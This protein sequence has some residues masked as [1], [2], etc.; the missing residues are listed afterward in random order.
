MATPIYPIEGIALDSTGDMVADSLADR[1]VNLGGAEEHV[2]K[3]TGTVHYVDATAGSD[4]NDGLNP[5]T[6]FETIGFGIAASAAG[7]AL[8]VKAGAYDEVG[9]DMNLVGLELW[10]EIGVRILDSTP[11]TGLIVS[12]DFCRVQ[13]A[14]FNGAGAIGLAVTG[15]NCVLSR[16]GAL[17]CTVGFDID[18][19]G[20]ALLEMR[21]VAHTV[22][23]FDIAGSGTVLFQCIATGLGAATRGFYLSSSGADLCVLADCSSI[24]NG[25]AGYE[26]VAAATSNIIRDSITGNGDGDRIDGG[27]GN[28]WANFVREMETEH[29]EHILPRPDGEGAAGAPAEINADAA[30]ETNAAATTQ[31]YWGEPVAAIQ[32]AVLTGDWNWVGMN[33]FAT[34]TG[35]DFRSYAYK[36]DFSRCS[37]RD[38]GNN[39]DEGA[40]AL[41]VADGTLFETDDLVWIRSTYKTDGE[42]Q[43]V[44]TSIANVVTVVRE[45]S[46]FGAPN[47][48]I[49]WNHTTNA[50]GTE[51]MYVIHRDGETA[52][53]GYQFDFGAGSARDMVITRWHAQKLMN[54]NDGVVVRTINGSDSVNDG[55]FSCSI[56]YSE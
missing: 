50:P 47:T 34:T 49:R 14:V 54:A 35:K 17:G 38:A 8:T 27:A 44:V 36:I 12:A 2:P 48:G 11:G 31:D 10:C 15:D 56:I 30:D 24:A 51:T 40:T 53:E 23:G 42:I 3:F 19:I 37:E 26:I 45:T 4:A 46:Q 18:G 5:N 28:F 55:N 21:S 20:C 29:N 1:L 9:L 16:L 43:K 41:T 52:S 25:T 6:A 22:T 13:G 33:I 32:P 7:D 39:W